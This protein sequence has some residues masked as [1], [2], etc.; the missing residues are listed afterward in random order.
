MSAETEHKEQLDLFS[1]KVKQK[2]EDHR[3]P[4][5][6]GCWEQIEAKVSERPR[7]SL[8][9]IGGWATAAAAVIAL[10]LL[11]RLGDPVPA[12]D[13]GSQE[14]G[15]VADKVEPEVEQAEPG[16]V[17]LPDTAG[18]DAFPRQARERV[19]RPMKKMD[20]I[21]RIDTIAWEDTFVDE[22]EVGLPAEAAVS[23]PAAKTS[24][25]RHQGPE[26]ERRR[27]RDL[28]AVVDK[29]K[30][31]GGKWQVGANMGTG[32][33]VSLGLNLQG[34]ESQGGI[35]SN[36]PNPGYP[37]PPIEEKPDW[38]MK[39]GPESFSNVDCAPPLSFGFTVRKNLNNRIALESGLVYTYLYSKMN[40]S[41]AVSYK[42]TL[43]LH[44][45]GIPVNL[46]VKLWDNPNWNVYVSG[47]FMVEKGLRSLYHLEAYRLD[48]H[49]AGTVRSGIHGLQGS[50]NLSI[51][52]SYRV[53][54]DWNLYLEPRYSYY[55]DN[56]QPM[57]Y[58][59]ENTT[60]IGV[61]AGVRFEF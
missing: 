44:Y 12:P 9:R 23:K 13:A 32:G 26:P 30:A 37:F 55:F 20:V 10:L 31:K 16:K 52:V 27:T 49:K 19:A 4:V 40:E 56:N 57:S 42:A 15:L 14:N 1:L 2:L 53:Y 33:H 22:A 54:R 41:G 29:P 18:V 60:L 47:G 39:R 35:D 50:L 46:V 5:D 28:I 11:I 8:W 21:A 17:D 45:L 34:D 61:G 48:E 6:S 24:S 59:T 25:V 7:R 51:G 36:D 38:N 43:G 58:R 3:L